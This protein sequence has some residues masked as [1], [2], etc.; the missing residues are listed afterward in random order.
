[1]YII[2][3][4]YTCRYCS[5]VAKSRRGSADSSHL[6]ADLSPIILNLLSFFHY[7]KML[8]FRGLQILHKKALSM[9]RRRS[10]LLGS[11]AQGVERGILEIS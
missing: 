2:S 9:G 4:I 11:A 10:N 3:C 5:N 8:M 1:M 7:A 6:P